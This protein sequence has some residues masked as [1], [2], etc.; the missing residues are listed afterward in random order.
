MQRTILTNQK[1]VLVELTN[2][3]AVFCTNL[4]LATADWPVA[5][6]TLDEWCDG[7]DLLV[8]AKTNW[9][10]QLFRT[11]DHGRLIKDQFSFI[12]SL[13]SSEESANYRTSLNL[14][15]ERL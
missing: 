4:T 1:R 15:Y 3:R 14:G 2:Q 10:C 5:P 12:N 13:S 8:T 9:F 6:D 11:Q 7:G